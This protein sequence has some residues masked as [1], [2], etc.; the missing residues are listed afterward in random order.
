MIEVIARR[1]RN[2][3]PYEADDRPYVEWWLK[4]GDEIRVFGREGWARVGPVTVVDV[5]YMWAHGEV[6]EEVAE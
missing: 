1:H 2:E 5:D 6:K 4:S 3:D